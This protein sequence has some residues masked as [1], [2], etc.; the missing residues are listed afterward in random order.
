MARMNLALRL[1]LQILDIDRDRIGAG[2]EL[3]AVDLERLALGVVVDDDQ[4]AGH[5]AAFF[6]G[7]EVELLAV[8]PEHRLD[9]VHDRVGLGLLVETRLA[10]VLGDVVGLSLGGHVVV[11]DQL[12][13]QGHH[14][15]RLGKGLDR[16]DRQRALL[17]LA[18]HLEVPFF[19][20][21][22]TLASDRTGVLIVGFSCTHDLIVDV[23]R[24]VGDLPC[25]RNRFRLGHLNCTPKNVV[26]S[27]K[28]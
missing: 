22:F 16:A 28:D 6:L 3:G 23:L 21:Y 15:E 7:D 19:G 25:Y 26:A 27:C 11:F 12:L 2:A 10:P 9:V 4:L 17:G 14:L 1:E 5:V 24:V 18:P 20:R 8:D 13:G